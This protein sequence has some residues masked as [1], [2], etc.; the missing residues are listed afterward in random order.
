MVGLW[1]TYVEW[2]QLEVGEGLERHQKF[3]PNQEEEL[4]K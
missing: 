4:V 2:V 1:V 3:L